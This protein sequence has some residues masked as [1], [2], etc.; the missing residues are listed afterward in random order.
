MTTVNELRDY[1]RNFTLYPAL[2]ELGKLSADLFGK[3]KAYKNITVGQSGSQTVTQWGLAFIAWCLIQSSN[4]GRRRTFEISN[5]LRASY[6]Y[7]DLEDPFVRDKNSFALFNRM[8]QEQFWWQESIV[9]PFSRQYLLLA[10]PVGKRNISARS[11]VEQTF[12]NEFGLSMSDFLLIGA[13]IAAYCSKLAVYFDLT[14]LSKRQQIPQLKEVLT[15]EKLRRFLKTTAKTYQGIRS[16]KENSDRLIVPGYE[17]YA[18]N[19]LFK[20]PIVRADPRFHYKR[21]LGKF[22]VPNILLLIRK[23]TH[24]LYWELRDLYKSKKSPK[25]LIDFG[26]IFQ[27][28]VHFLLEKFFS[29]SEVI[30]LQEKDRNK[31]ICDF[32]VVQDV[33]VLFECKASLIPFRARQTFVEQMV[34]P[35]LRRVVV[36]GAKQLLSTEQLLRSNKLGQVG[37]ASHRKVFKVIVIYETLY[38][39]EEPRWKDWINRTLRSA[40]VLDQYPNSDG[41]IYLMDVQHLE[42]GEEAFKRTSLGNIFQKKIELDKSQDPGIKHGFNQVFQNIV[43]STNLSCPT[44]EE[45]YKQFFGL[46]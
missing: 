42:Q 29:K 17:K 37:Y 3:H 12:L 18:F 5:L 11:R 4:D 20:H 19:P 14:R 26:E 24:G 21:T 46:Q 25:F 31:R 32:A 1:L 35:W 2:G 43:K 40:K 13:Y 23:M 39:A 36:D 8:A 45:V 15:A 44:L 38:I 30:R 34:G 22:V 9:Q 27:D 28:Y 16:F 41:E 10:N 7:S 33:V 6:M